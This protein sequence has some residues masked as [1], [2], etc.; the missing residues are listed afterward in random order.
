MTD[1]FTPYTIINRMMDVLEEN[2]AGW[3]QLQAFK[4]DLSYCAPETMDAR[5]WGKTRCSNI[6]N[7]CMKHFNDN[8][9]IHD[10]YVESVKR[11]SE[12]GFT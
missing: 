4:K 2:S 6:V 1:L 3:L 8:E 12:T 11:Y 10:I 5:F 7:L 9:K